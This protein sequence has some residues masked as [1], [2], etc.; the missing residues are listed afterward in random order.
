MDIE[1]D[2]VLREE[3]VFSSWRQAL[4]DKNAQTVVALDRAFLD[5]PGRF[6][7]GLVR[8]AEFDKEDRVRAFSTRV[9]GKMAKQE[10]KELFLRL[11]EKDKWQYVRENAAWGLGQIAAKEAAPALQRAADKDPDENV[12]QAAAEALKRCQ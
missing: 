6:R 4:R 3:P 9:L 1:A 10:D 11:L 2:L 12:R 8:L 5:N 7:A